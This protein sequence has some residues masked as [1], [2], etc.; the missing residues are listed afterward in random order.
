MVKSTDTVDYTVEDEETL[1]TT[2]DTAEADAIKEAID[3]AIQY[4]G[5][6][7]DPADYG[8]WV[9]GIPVL[10]EDGLDAIGCADWFKDISL[11]LI[12]CY[13]RGMRIYGTYRIHYG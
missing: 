12:T 13:L 5:A 11:I 10:I 7:P 1:E 9:P 2:E 8:V 4:D 3:L 6:V